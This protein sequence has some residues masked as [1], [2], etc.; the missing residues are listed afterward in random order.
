MD[1]DKFNKLSETPKPVRYLVWQDWAE[2]QT[3]LE[4]ASAYFKNREI[5]KPLVVEIGILHNE[6]QAFYRKFLGADYIGIDIEANN[7]PD[8]LGNSSDPGTVIELKKLLKGRH[9]DLLFI[10]GNHGYGGVRADYEL[11]GA[12]TKHLIAFHDVHSVLEDRA[13]GVNRYWN[14][15]IRRNQY[16]TVVFHRYN[17]N[18]SIKENRYMN[19]GIGVVIK[20]Q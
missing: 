12:L 9:I 6:Q 13:L 19:E 5:E 2:W 11:Y 3:F 15:I 17:T 20:G 10:D 14:E 16:M 4:F 7:E 8:I 18:V 1:I